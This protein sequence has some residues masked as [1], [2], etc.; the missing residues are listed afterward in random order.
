MPSDTSHPINLSIE[1]LLEQFSSSSERKKRSLISFVEERNNDL[2]T[3]PSSGLNAFDPN[4]DD[5]S[6]GF[7]LQVL[8]KHQPEFL[9][10]ILGDDLLTGWFKTSSSIG[11]DYAPFQKMLLDE[12]F[13]EADRFTSSMLRHLAGKEAEERGYVY[14]SEVPNMPAIDLITLDRLWIA[15]SQGKFGFSVQGRLLDKLGGNYERLWP[16]IGWKKDGVWT[17]YPSAFDWTLKAPDGHMP[18]INQLR[19]VRLMDAVLNQP[20][21][22]SRR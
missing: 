4:S 18:L 2:I 8:N 14:F 5:W 7:I 13:E 3:I 20:E 10:N 12:A 6:A 11:I 21:L 17:R 1:E 22:K 19:G 15:Y 9:K 16:K